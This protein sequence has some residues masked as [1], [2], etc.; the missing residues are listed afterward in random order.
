MDRA[1]KPTKRDIVTIIRVEAWHQLQRT[2]GHYAPAITS[3]HEPEPRGIG[4]S[5]ISESFRLHPF[6]KE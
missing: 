2:G 3:R 4:R 6:Q 5:G 1:G